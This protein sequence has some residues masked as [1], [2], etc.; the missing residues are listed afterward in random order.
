MFDPGLQF[1]PTFSRRKRDIADNYWA[2]IVRELETGCTCA[3]FDAHGKPRD[4]RCVCS[5]VPLPT[6]RPIRVFSPAG[7][8]MTLRSPSRLKPLLCELLE[9]LISI[10]Q[11]P[12]TQPAGLAVRP[13]LLHPQYQQNASHVAYLR[14]ILDA[15]LIQQEIEHG[16]FDPSGVFQAVGDIVRCYCAPMRDHVVDQM[17]SLAKSCA[18]GGSGSKTDAVRAIRQCFEIMELM[19]LVRY[20]F[21]T[22]DLSC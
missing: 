7:D 8:F 19:K 3:T 18:P 5:S 4:R 11:P 13:Q 9:V 12:I 21:H 15:D 17:V 2:C 10:I 14:A 20:R 1:R 6:G 16:L 22:F